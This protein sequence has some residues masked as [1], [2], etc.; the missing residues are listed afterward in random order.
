MQMD[1]LLLPGRSE[2][3]VPKYFQP[4]PQMQRASSRHLSG[5][6]D[7]PVNA[8]HFPLRSCVIV[9]AATWC[10]IAV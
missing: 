2:H 8:C 4:G 7:M 5:E 3:A 1:A 9:S 10:V 6:N